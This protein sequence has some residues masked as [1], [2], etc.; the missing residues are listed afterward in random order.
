[1]TQYEP[2]RRN[3][4]GGL[5]A[6][7]VAV[8][9]LAACGSSGGDDATGS[10]AG[11]PSASTGPGASGGATS[12]GGG[13]PTSEIPVGG[14]KIF[15]NQRIVVTQPTAGEFKAFSAICTHQGCTVSRIS[16]GT[17]DCACHGSQF[18]IEDGSVKGGPAPKALP[19]K[20][21]TVTG[22]SLTVS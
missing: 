15:A 12:G 6:A 7:G 1:M 14:G 5:A 10:T 22:N 20:N 11:D 16:G 9:L 17:I 13:I 2:S 18:S 8:P 19:S 3:L 21:V 4:I